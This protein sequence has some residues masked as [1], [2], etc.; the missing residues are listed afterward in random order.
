MLE[1]TSTENELNVKGLRTPN[2]QCAQ[3]KT[4]WFSV[5]YSLTRGNQKTLCLQGQHGYK[6]YAY[7]LTSWTDSTLVKLNFLLFYYPGVLWINSQNYMDLGETGNPGK[8]K[9][10]RNGTIMKYNCYRSTNKMLAPFNTPQHKEGLF[11]LYSE[12]LHSLISHRYI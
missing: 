9:W 1:H 2:S 3:G 8:E 12:E 4:E 5:C 6:A 11:P 7:M 10:R